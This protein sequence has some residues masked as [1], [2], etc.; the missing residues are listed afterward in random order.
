MDFEYSDEVKKLS[1]PSVL[2][3][4]HIYPNEGRFEED[5]AAAANRWQAPSVVEKLKPNAKAAHL[6][7]LFLPHFES[8]AELTNLEYAPLAEIVG[9]VDCASKALNC[10]VPDSG[11]MEVLDRYG[12]P[13]QKE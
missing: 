11:N 2:M 10:S 7:N 13:E 6:W 5:L 9:R 8:G 1:A 3:D 12:T 4:E